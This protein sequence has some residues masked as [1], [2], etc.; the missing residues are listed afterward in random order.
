MP[1]QQPPSTPRAR[2]VGMHPGESAR[3]SVEQRPAAAVTEPRSP[4]VAAGEPRWPMASAVIAAIVLTIL[5]PKD[6][7]AGPP[8]LLPTLEGPLLIALVVGDPGA[9]DR[10]ST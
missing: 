10:R 7:R 3:V 4:G 5:L 8:W 6:V 2:P 9:I 1:G